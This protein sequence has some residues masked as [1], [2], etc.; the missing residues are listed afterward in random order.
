[1]RNSALSNCWIRRSWRL[2]PITNSSVTSQKRSSNA[3]RY[4]PSS[5]LKVMTSKI[6]K[7]SW[8]GEK[9]YLCKMNLIKNR[10]LIFW[11]SFW[12]AWIDGGKN[13]HTNRTWRQGASSTKPTRLCRLLAS[14]SQSKSRKVAEV[15][16][17]LHSKMSHKNLKKI[18]DATPHLKCSNSGRQCSRNRLDQCNPEN[19]L[20]RIKRHQ[21]SI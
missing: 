4:S 8:L 2:R 13:T 19:L 17:R 12:T 18:R 3:S 1:M 7:G 21:H 20:K 9:L 15:Q 6:Y 10:R 5:A 16:R 14:Y 11:L